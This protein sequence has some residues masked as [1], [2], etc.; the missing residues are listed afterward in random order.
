MEPLRGVR[1]PQSPNAY[2]P[3]PALTPP[4][5]CLAEDH[6]HPLVLTHGPTALPKSQGGAAS[7]QPRLTGA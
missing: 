4:T 7:P 1:A 6:V 2:S 5:Q 3:D